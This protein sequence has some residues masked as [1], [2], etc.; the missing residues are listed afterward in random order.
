MATLK[1]DVGP[2]TDVFAKSAESVTTQFSKEDNDLLTR[3][4]PGTP[5]GELFRQ[6]W[7]P[8]L[9]VSHLEEPGGKPRRIRLLGEDLVAF[10]SR[11]GTVGLVGAYCPH[12]LAPLFF[13]HIEDDGVRCPYHGWKIGTNGACL[14]MPNVPE[15]HQFKEKISHPSYPVKEHGGVIWTYMG[16]SENLPELPEFE[17]TMVPE[18]QRDFRLFHHECNYL[19]AMEGGID[20]THVMWLHSP[21]DLSDDDTAADHQ[22]T[23]QR[24][25]NSSGARTPESVEIVEQPGGFIY[26]AKRALD[27]DRNL[28]RINR[29]ILPFYTM[30]PGGDR[31]S[32]RMW[33]PID[34]EQCVKWM[35]NWYPTRE[36][37]EQTKEKPRPWKQ[38]EDYAPE[39]PEPYGHVRPN[40][41]KANDYLINWDTQKNKRIGVA[42][43]NLQDKCVQENEGPGPILDRTKENLCVGDMT[44]IRARRILRNAAL[45]LK[46]KGEAPIGVRDPSIYRVRAASIAVPKSENWVEFTK[47]S[48]TF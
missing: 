18:D 11:A 29:F 3:V 31:R 15:E 34:D 9:P 38:E 14:E 35:Y 2:S 22:P 16:R 7:L 45:A 5:M 37:M 39:V 30:P 47:D 10:R 13:G 6:Y 33:V 19:Q 24:L 4:G 1:E 41:Q 27:A 28:W 20:P 17:F 21:Y 36:I 44:I 42:G 12:R 26:G 8:V 23:Q 32:G 40:A 43:V 25:A 46:D 48:V